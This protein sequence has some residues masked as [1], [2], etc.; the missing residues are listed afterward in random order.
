[1]I[2]LLLA[3]SLAASPQE[4]RTQESITVE[5]ILIDVRVTDG[6]G[7]PIPN[8]EPKD[9]RVKIDGVP[10][11]IESVEWI[12]ETAGARELAELDR[13]SAK[14]SL[15][16][17]APKGRLLVFFFQTD[18]ARERVRVSGQM[19]ILPYADQ[20][21]DSLEPE[22]RVAVV[23]F[24]SHLKFRL[25][26]SDDHDAISKAMRDS[27]SID[28]PPRPP[29]VPMPSLARALD[30]QSLRNAVDS[31]RALFL[32]GN[33]LLPIPG[34][35]SLILF[36]WGLGKLAGGR[37]V[38]E[39]RYAIAQRA[40]E[41]SRTSVFS[42]DITQ[43][44]WHSLSAGL[45]KAAED[46]GGFYADTFHFPQLAIDRLQRALEGHYELEVRRPETKAKGIHDIDVE[47]PAHRTALVMSRR[48]FVDK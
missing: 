2:P 21:L 16:V 22:D 30:D 48:T 41:A 14:S 12:P 24:D 20:L 45:E 34:P 36:G 17:P 26:F 32:L 39:K 18:F 1:V 25:D 4:M 40:L 5:R 13:E 33:A 37:V 42:I 15:E 27:L 19:K 10:A 9:F 6:R 38:M 28:D 31:D 29:S 3:L 23:S 7:D 11:K 43:A 35:K 46:T 44:D 8:L 47:V